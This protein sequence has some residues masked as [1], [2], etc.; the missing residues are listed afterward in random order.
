MSESVVGPHADAALQ[1]AFA[2]HLRDPA[3][4]PAPP[5]LDP[6]RVATYRRLFF[7]NVEAIL[8]ANF[9]V[10]S[11]L[12][13]A[14]WVPLVRRFYAEFASHVPLFTELAREFVRFLGERPDLHGERPFLPELAEYEWVELELM[15]EP[16]ELDALPVDREGDLLDG[17]P[18]VSPA[19][20]LLICQYPV[21]QIR[22]DFQPRA[23]LEQP[24]FLVVWR[25]R[26]DQMG[27]MELNAVS[28]RLLALLGDAGTRSGQEAVS[29]IAAAMGLTDSAPLLPA[30]REQLELWRARD[31]LLG[32]A[33]L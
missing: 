30:A 14:E 29:A 12:L 27:F 5:G 19:S 24:A 28:A 20:R 8:S 22:P 32:T 11:R 23:A 26:A 18:V 16:T 9:P 21:H 13:G 17:R 33:R 2:R 15:L 6:A 31:L 7:N 25:D 3:R 4:E 1:L 10:I